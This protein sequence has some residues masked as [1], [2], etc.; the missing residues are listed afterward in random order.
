LFLAHNDFDGSFLRAVAVLGFWTGGLSG[1]LALYL[2][3]LFPTEVRATGQGLC[4]NGGRVLAAGGVWL[5]T[6]PLDVR[7]DYPLAC[8]VVSLAFAGGAILSWWL[9]EPYA[10]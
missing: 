10:T 2:P 1:W 8:A 5:T 4:Y 9:P 3:A 7:G 6:V